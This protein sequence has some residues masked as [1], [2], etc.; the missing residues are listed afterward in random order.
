MH[1]A[2]TKCG[3]VPKCPVSTVFPRPAKREYGSVPKYILRNNSFKPSQLGHSIACYTALPFLARCM[4]ELAAELLEWG[5]DGG[6]GELAAYAKTRVNL[7]S[8]NARLHE[9]VAAL[10]A[11]DIDCVQELVGAK[12]CQM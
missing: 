10:Q 11:M 8:G 9:V 7:S 12:R 3:S 4:A 2:K 6:P 5:Y 1:P